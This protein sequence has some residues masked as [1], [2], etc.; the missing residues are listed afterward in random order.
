MKNVSELKGYTNFHHQGRTIFESFLSSLLNCNVNIQIHSISDF[1]NRMGIDITSNVMRNCYDWEDREDEVIIVPK[2]MDYQTMEVFAVLPIRLSGPEI[3]RLPR[4]Y[5]DR[6]TRAI[7]KQLTQCAEQK[8]KSCTTAFGTEFEQFVVSYCLTANSKEASHL[9]HLISIISKLSRTTFEANDFSTAFIYTR[10]A[11]EYSRNQRNG[12]VLWLSAVYDFFRT[13]NIDKRFWYLCDGN[14]TAYLIDHH[15]KIK[16]MY[17]FGNKQGNFLDSYSLRNTLLGADILFRVTGS[18]QVS[19]ID[20]TGI[21]FCY[22]ENKWR[23]RNK[24]L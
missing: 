5:L 19:I 21:E 22:I 10:S 1:E 12:K 24:F 13:A 8:F 6:V 4:K 23:I 15:L 9:E 2:V 17:V 16:S 11:H 14:T 18:N 20:S 7:S 3:H